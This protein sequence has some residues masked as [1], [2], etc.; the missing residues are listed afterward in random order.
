MYRVEADRRQERTSYADLEEFLTSLDMRIAVERWGDFH[1]PRIAQLIQR[2][3][4]FN[5][6]TRR[7][8]EHQC[9]AIMQDGAGWLAVYAKLS[10]RLG[11][12]GLI[13]VVA[14]CVSGSDLAIRD[15][16]MS[17]R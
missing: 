12:H 1:L 4:Q 9:R 11:D 2:S 7:L 17:C 16:L 13:S 15:W 10:D 3:N 6:T 8:S 14:C 5:L